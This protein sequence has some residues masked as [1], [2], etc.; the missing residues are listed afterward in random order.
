M[1]TYNSQM[2]YLGNFADMDTNETNSDAENA[3]LISGTYNK[4][5]HDLHARMVR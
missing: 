3:N 4:P 2:F 1:T 5:L